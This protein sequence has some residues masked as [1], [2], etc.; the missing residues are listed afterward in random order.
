MNFAWIFFSVLHLVHVMYCIGKGQNRRLT[1]LYPTWTIRPTMLQL[2]KDGWMTC[3][4]TSFS[5]VFQLYQDD[6]R[7]I[8]KSCV[9]WNSIYG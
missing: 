5:T 7:L 9:Q 8:M 3:D 1:I 2:I 4:F 6:R